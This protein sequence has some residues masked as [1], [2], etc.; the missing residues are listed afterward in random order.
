MPRRPYPF[1]QPVVSST[2]EWPSAASSV[3]RFLCCDGVDGN[4]AMSNVCVR[5]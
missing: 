3:E 4:V 2:E 5:K 1:M